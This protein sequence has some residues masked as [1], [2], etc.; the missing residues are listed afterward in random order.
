MNHKRLEVF[1]EFIVFG[2]IVGITEDILAIKLTTGEPI[3]PRVVLLVVLIAIPFAVVGEY[4]V[5]QVDFTSWLRRVLPSSTRSKR[6]R[7]K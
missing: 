1:L 6:S 5:D 4:V 7:L 3:T 2:I